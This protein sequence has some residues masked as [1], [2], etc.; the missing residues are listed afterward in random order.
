MRGRNQGSA[1]PKLLQFAW[2]CW[3]TDWNAFARASIASEGLLGHLLRE[4]NK[5]QHLVFANSPEIQLSSPC[6]PAVS[7]SGELKNKRK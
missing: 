4:E 7:A 5:S 1:P 6:T 3:A 2:S